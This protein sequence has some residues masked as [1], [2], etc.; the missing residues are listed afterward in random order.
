MFIMFLPSEGERK[1]GEV[2]AYSTLSRRALC[3]CR[4]RLHAAVHT[5][6]HA[7]SVTPS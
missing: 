6:S 1:T 2:D 3:T 4:P 5:I 7:E